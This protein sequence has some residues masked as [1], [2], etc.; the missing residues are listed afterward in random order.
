MRAYANLTRM[1]NIKKATD[2]YLHYSLKGLFSVPSLF[3][4]LFIIISYTFCCGLCYDCVIFHKKGPSIT[5]EA[6]TLVRQTGVEP[7]TNWFVVSF[8]N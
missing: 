8:V 1:R 5:W 7:A 4:M 2:N 6:L 3:I